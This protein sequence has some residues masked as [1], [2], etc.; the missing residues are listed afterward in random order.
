[1][2]ESES[3]LPVLLRD[4]S[5]SEA[6]Q[7]AVADV[8][9]PEEDGF[10]AAEDTRF[11]IEVIRA[12]ALCIADQARSWFKCATYR[13]SEHGFV[14]IYH[15]SAITGANARIILTMGLRGGVGPSV[16]ECRSMVMFDE[17]RQ[18]ERDG[19]NVLALGEK[20]RVAGQ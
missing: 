2:L 9:L 8:E 4:N 1:M 17:L 6:Y 19:C 10:D 16:G 14:N 3:G 12:H 11:T 7:G 13:R 5:I 20:L 15:A 18:C